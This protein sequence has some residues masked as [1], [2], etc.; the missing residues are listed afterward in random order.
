MNQP[1]TGQ[2]ES[3]ENRILAALGYPIWIVALVVMLTDMKKNPF[4]RLHAVQALGYTIAW[5]VVYTALLIVIPAVGLWRLYFLW[6]LL[7]LAWLVGAVYY[8]YEAYQGRMF[9][10]PIVSKFTAQY[11]VTEK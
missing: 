4:M 2:A 9:S 6:P 3:N 1:G 7:R 8:A 10:I 5:V 11:A